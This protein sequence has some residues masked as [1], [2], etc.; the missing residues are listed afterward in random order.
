M[1]SKR[2]VNGKTKWRGRVYLY[3]RATSAVREQ[4]KTFDRKTDAQEWERVQRKKNKRIPSR[5][6]PV[7]LQTYLTSDKLDQVL[8]GLGAHTKEVYRSHIRVRIF[9]DLGLLQL[10]RITPSHLEAAQLSWQ[11]QV[12]TS[13]I[14]GTR[15]CLSRIMKQA[16]SDGY[17]TVN[18]VD[19]S[20]R[21][22]A[23]PRIVSETTLSPV[24]AN[25]LIEILSKRIE[26]KDVL[27]FI[28]IALH[29]GM[30]A[31]EIEALQEKD[32]DLSRRTITVSRAY[33]GYS[34]RTLQTTK[35]GKGRTVPIPN[36]LG[37]AFTEL[38][39]QIGRTADPLLRKP[40]GTRLTATS[41]VRN[42]AVNWNATLE[43]LGYPAFKVRD[44]RAT[45]IVGWLR[46][47]V[48][49]STVREWAGH[50]DLK[51]TTK[52]ARIA[53][54]DLAHGLALLDAVDRAEER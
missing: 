28:L 44:L 2:T 4:T 18:P 10:D 50:A 29:T 27:L 46:A 49:I 47:G 53:G 36:A 1:A 45:A 11:R 33:S 54:T 37:R 12:G 15:N 19:D 8:Y 51:T 38:H 48:P 20:R 26:N 24:D 9:P 14:A 7:T 32:V 17:T 31:G 6:G 5:R 34:P 39:P 13:T 21:L 23:Q 42:K 3:D 35:S 52:Y 22:K 16:I 25:R 43:Q 41:V 30:R 40:D